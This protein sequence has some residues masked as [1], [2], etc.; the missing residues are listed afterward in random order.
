[1]PGFIVG[2]FPDSMLQVLRR[3]VCG[4]VHNL[5][6]AVGL[7]DVMIGG[8]WVTLRIVPPPSEVGVRIPI[9]P[10]KQGVDCLMFL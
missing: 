8:D 6:V 2:T 5:R 1:M 7:V 3:C 9:H 10:R 4:F